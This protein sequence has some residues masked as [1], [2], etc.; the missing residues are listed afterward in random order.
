MTLI[1]DCF[2]ALFFIFLLLSFVQLLLQ[3]PLFLFFV[4]GGVELSDA[5]RRKWIF[6]LLH[7]AL[8]EVIIQGCKSHLPLLESDG[9]FGLLL[10]AQREFGNVILLTRVSSCPSPQ[11]LHLSLLLDQVKICRM[12]LLKREQV[13]H[14][15]HGHVAL[16]AVLS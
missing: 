7:L 2:A 5:I 9:F 6:S 8:N 15:L 3:D 4:W 13:V 1:Q 11:A 14:L 10:L 12:A 16:V